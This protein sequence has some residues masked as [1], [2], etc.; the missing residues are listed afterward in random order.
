MKEFAVSTDARNGTDM[1]CQCPGFRILV[2]VDNIA[3]EQQES[4]MSVIL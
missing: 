3:F 2:N 1:F 4:M